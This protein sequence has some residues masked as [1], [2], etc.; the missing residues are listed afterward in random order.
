MHDKIWEYCKDVHKD[1]TSWWHNHGFKDEER[2]EMGIEIEKYDP[3]EVQV[4]TFEI[5]KYSFKGGQKFVCVTKEE[6]DT[7]PLA[8]RNGSRFKE[9]IWE[10]FVCLFS[11]FTLFY[12]FQ[13]LGGNFQD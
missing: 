8:R 9:M 5:K 2:N 1:S 6:D 7:L 13:Q 12:S 3:P 10:E 4:E 11:C